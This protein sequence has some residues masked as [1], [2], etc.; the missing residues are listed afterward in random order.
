[1]RKMD[2]PIKDVTTVTDSQRLLSDTRKVVPEK[3]TPRVIVRTIDAP[4]KDPAKKVRR[5]K[6][7][8]SL[9]PRTVH[10]ER[11]FWR[12]RNT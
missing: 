8:A 1:M 4:A 12:P 7:I 10:F 9:E 5:S 2:A 6:G 11:E 3:Q